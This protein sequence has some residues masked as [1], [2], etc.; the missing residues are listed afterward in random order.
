MNYSAHN[1]VP[2]PI[3]SLK[4]LAWPNSSLLVTFPL[5]SC[6]LILVDVRV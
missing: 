2:Y 3:C 6:L 5:H 4:R 1:V